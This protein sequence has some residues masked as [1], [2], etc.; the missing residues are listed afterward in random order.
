MLNWVTAGFRRM[1]T[2]AEVYQIIHGA[3]G[4]CAAAEKQVSP[5]TRNAF[6]FR[7]TWMPAES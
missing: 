6:R 3:K 5:F 7:N 2:T 1:K 4:H